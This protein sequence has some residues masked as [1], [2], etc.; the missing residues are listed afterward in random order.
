LVT[1]RLTP[2]LNG[3]SLT[4]GGMKTDAP[5]ARGD[6]R[7]P[8]SDHHELR[9]MMTDAKTVQP[10]T[11]KQPPQTKTTPCSVAMGAWKGCEYG[12]HHGRSEA[13]RAARGGSRG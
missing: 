10:E 11:D 2:V 9:L 6:V 13:H 7:R 4:L 12:A 1:P 5:R 8:T 3:L